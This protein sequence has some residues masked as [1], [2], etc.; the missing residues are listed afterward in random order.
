MWGFPRETQKITFSVLSKGDL[1]AI[2][3]ATLDL[4]ET[5]GIKIFSQKCLKILEQAGCT[6]D[7]KKS[8]ALIPSHLVEEALRKNRAS[9]RLCARNPKYDANLDGRHV[10]ITTDGNGTHAFD[11][12]TGQR[13]MS[14][15]DDIVK[16]AIVS[17][18][19][20]AVHIYW[21]MVSS[22]DFPPH[23]RHLH[24]LEASL[25]HTEKTRHRGDHHRSR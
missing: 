22:Q 3:W 1:D 5:I 7:W 10:Y 17:D 20:D 25:M 9:I 16:S 12:E 15:K 6:V 2:H 13:R 18:Q 8:S 24:D 19:L 21:P 11:L 23:T 4:L 14:T